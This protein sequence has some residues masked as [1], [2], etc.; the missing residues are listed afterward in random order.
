MTTLKGSDSA[1]AAAALGSYDL[2]GGAHARLISLSENATFLI[3][4]DRPIAVLRVYRSGYQQESAMRSEL[5]WITALRAGGVIRTPGV[6]PAKDGEL[7]TLVQIEGEKRGCALFEFI[8][9]E[10]LGDEDLETFAQVGRTAAQLHLQVADWKPPTGFERF[11]WNL[12]SILDDGAR[13]GDWRHGPG[14]TEEGRALLEAAE[15]K[16]RGALADYPLSPSTSGL[17]HGDLRAANILA[18]SSGQLWVI[19]FDDCGFSWLLWDLCSTTT[20]IEHLPNVDDVVSAWLRGYRDLRPLSDRD[21]AVIPDL[22]FLRRLHI[23]AWLGSHPE[24][25]LAAELGVSYTAATYEIARVY[26]DGRFL[27]GVDVIA[28]RT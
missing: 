24:S 19:D 1:F 7:L 28:G 3:E 26:L 20:F 18:D 6:L 14:H 22:V 16:I 23:L 2:P 4:T 12:S 13:W 17:V 9:G 10:H 5:A 25:D 8:A 21:L 11:T 15:A 27:A